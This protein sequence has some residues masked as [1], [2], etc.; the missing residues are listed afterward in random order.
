MTAETEEITK[1]VKTE[2]EV[3]VEPERILEIPTAE[4]KVKTGTAMTDVKK[5]SVPQITDNT[6]G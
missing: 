5:Q 2:M 4:E 1:E 6:E 3:S